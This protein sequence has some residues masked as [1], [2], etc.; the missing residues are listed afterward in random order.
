MKCSACGRHMLG[1]SAVLAAILGIAACGGGRGTTNT[2][3]TTNS[4]PTADAGPDLTVNPSS[5]VTLGGRGTDDDGTIESYDW[6]QLSGPTVELAGANTSVA[7]FEAPERPGNSIVLLEFSL[8]VTDNEGAIST[9]R[10]TITIRRPGFGPTVS[11]GS[12]RVALAG[13]TVILTGVAEGSI[14]RSYLWEQ[15]SGTPV[16]LDSLGDASSADMQRMAIHLLPYRFYTAARFTVPDGAGQGEV[17]VFRL[18]AGDWDGA[19]TSDEVQVTVQDMEDFVEVSGRI[20]FDY[21]PV[22]R[23]GLQYSAT[24]ARPVR[25]VTLQVWDDEAER[26]VD[27]TATDDDG[28]Y[29]AYAPRNAAAM[30]RARAEIQGGGLWDVQVVDYDGGLPGRCFDLPEYALYAMDSTPFPTTD[31][32]VVTDL[33]APSG[34]TGSAYADERVAAPFAILDTLYDAMQLVLSNEDVDFP[35]LHV[36]WSPDSSSAFF[37]PCGPS[38]VI[39]LRGI[40]NSDTDEYDRSVIFHEWGHYL[41]N[42]F[43]RDVSPGGAHAI[44]EHLDMTT[45]FDEG[46]ASALQAAVDETE[47][48]INSLGPQQGRTS[49]VSLESREFRNPGWFNEGSIFAILYDLIDPI[50]DDD[51]ALGF[52][53]IVDVVVHDLPEMR[54]LTSIFSFIARLKN[55]YPEHTAS[56]DSVVRSESIESIVDEWGSTET[57]AGYPLHS[58]ILPVYAQATVNGGS[59]NVCSVTDFGSV[60]TP[61]ANKLGIYRYIRFVVQSEGDYVAVA[62]LSSAPAES[63]VTPAVSVKTGGRWGSGNTTSCAANQHDNCTVRTHMDMEVGDQ[64]IAVWD[65]E[66]QGAAGLDLS[67]NTGRKCFD[68]EIIS[69]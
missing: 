67:G 55:R 52:A 49:S 21:V 46:F 26:I 50:N 5:T 33:H 6:T 3:Q 62:T 47:Y 36:Y 35:T 22:Q 23:N 53:P 37:R 1:V 66:N 65:Y 51:A 38:R 61:M 19:T 59:V 39:G 44:D 8:A 63:V 12:D 28:N 64:V 27:V 29:T 41:L 42:V 30:V 7:T 4:S 40:E 2:P 60:F 18:T 15:V 20:T 57:N 58:D 10:V 48:Y 9:D 68:V 45:A 25:G 32:A 13:R 31:H 24:E 14:I 34:W 69:Q 56:I 17:L 54:S 43:S 11:A 16:T